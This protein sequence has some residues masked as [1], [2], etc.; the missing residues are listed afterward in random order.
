MRAIAAQCELDVRFEKDILVTKRC[1][2]TKDAVE[3][4]GAKREVVAVDGALGSARDFDFLRFFLKPA[5]VTG[6]EF[7]SGKQNGRDCEIRFVLNR[8]RILALKLK[9]SSSRRS[10]MKG[11]SFQ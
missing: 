8:D 6:W 3:R 9:T 10:V 4:S 1:L 2:S 11:N 7:N 5:A